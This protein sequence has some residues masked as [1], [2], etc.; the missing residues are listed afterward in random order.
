MKTG[1]F[2]ENN[3]D[4]L[5]LLLKHHHSRS[6]SNPMQYRILRKLANT[7]MKKFASSIY[8]IKSSLMVDLDFTIT[9]PD[10]QAGYYQSRSEQM[11]SWWKY[12][13][14]MEKCQNLSNLMSTF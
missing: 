13:A 3:S 7:T 6:S 4:H 12:P 11:T 5:I 1:M 14:Q 10:G 9:I 2:G 8:G